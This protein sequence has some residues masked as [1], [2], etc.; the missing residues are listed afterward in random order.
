MTYLR[1]DRAILAQ[2]GVMF[3]TG[4]G[5]ANN[6]ETTT[7]AD[8]V[9]RNLIDFHALYDWTDWNDP[10]AQDKR[11]AAEMCEILIP[12]YVVAGFI[13]NLPNG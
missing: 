2:P 13:W 11:H 5:Y 7:L 4:V 9:Q 1:I 3:A 6:A 10:V 12:D 8:A